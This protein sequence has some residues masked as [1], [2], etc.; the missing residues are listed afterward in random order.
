MDRVL[1]EREKLLCDPKYSRFS[2]FELRIWN[3]VN[4]KGMFNASYRLETKYQK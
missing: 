4:V 1:N 3:R 2:P